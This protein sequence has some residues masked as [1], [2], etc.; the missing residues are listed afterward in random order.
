MISLF[1]ADSD[2]AFPALVRPVFRNKLVAAQMVQNGSAFMRHYQLIA[3]FLIAT[4]L[5]TFNVNTRASERVSERAR[6]ITYQSEGQTFYAL[7]LKPEMAKEQVDASRIVVL[8]DTSASQQG[9]Y[10]AAA[11]QS[12]QTLLDNLRPSDRV[13]LLAVDLSV[14][15]MTDA[16]ATPG[17]FELIAGYEA[18]TEQVPLGSTDLA[19][20]LKAAAAI[21]EQSNDGQ[22][23][24]VYIGDGISVANLLDTE[25]LTEVVGKLRKAHTSVTSF[26]IGPKLDTQLLAVLANQTGGNLYVQQPMVWQDDAAGITDAQA[27]ADN[28]RNAEAAGKQ[29]AG[30]THATVLWPEQVQFASELGKT[31]PAVM[32][33]LRSDRDTIVVGVTGDQLPELVVTSIQAGGVHGSASLSWGVLPEDSQEDHAFLAEVITAAKADDGLSLPTLGSAGLLETARLVGARMDQLTR[34]AER[35]IASGD[36]AAAQRIAQTVLQADPGNAQARTVQLVVE[37]S[38]GQSGPSDQLGG[39]TASEPVPAP[40]AASAPVVSAEGDISLVQ[41]AAPVFQNT[42]PAM[43]GGLH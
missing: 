16:P 30:S 21:L 8:F 14:K 3:S 10:R 4:A 19:G 13:E 43:R 35:A 18:L 11:L 17:S 29:L 26:A 6:L 2:R 27:Q 38:G 22:R 9:A 40:I 32:P 1:S 20:G 34:L 25:V 7:S 33:P 36:H 28:M 31:Y 24:V 5:L 23:S 37:Q 15:P 42:A 39:L 41:P 12:L